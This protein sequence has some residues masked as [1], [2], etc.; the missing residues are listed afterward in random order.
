MHSNAVEVRSKSASE[1]YGQFP[2]EFN[3]ERNSKIG[4]HLPK[5]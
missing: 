1:F 4:V 2:W 5:L 3:V